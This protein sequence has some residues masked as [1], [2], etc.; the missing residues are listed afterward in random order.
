MPVLVKP[1]TFVRKVD[2][3]L[4]SVSH[5]LR[6]WVR[7]KKTEGELDVF[8]LNSTGKQGPRV[9]FGSRT[10]ARMEYR[11]KRDARRRD[12]DGVVVFIQVIQ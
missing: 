5:R 6:T 8:E 1:G 7:I 10:D 12:R 3:F 9:S 4:S 11:V 2:D